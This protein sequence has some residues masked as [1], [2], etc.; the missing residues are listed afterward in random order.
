[1]S[2][3]EN[4]SKLWLKKGVTLKPGEVIASIWLYQHNCKK[5]LEEW[6]NV[7]IIG[8]MTAR[9]L[10]TKL[11]EHFETVQKDVATKRAKSDQMAGPESGTTA[12]ISTST[13]AEISGK[14]EDKDLAAA[15]ALDEQ[16]L[17]Q[18]LNLPLCLTA[19]R[20][21]KPL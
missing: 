14:E 21:F 16:G 2:F 4:Y 1:M 6:C 8:V 15:A 9:D 10:K 12:P 19:D 11:M 18:G 5:P 7:P 3:I 13:A 17:N 20:L